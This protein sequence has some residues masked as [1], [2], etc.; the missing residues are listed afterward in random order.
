MGSVTQQEFD[1]I[2]ASF[3]ERAER[4][5]KSA[6]KLLGDMYY[7]GPSGTEANVSAAFP[8]WKKAVENGDY[9]L[10][11]KVAYAYYTGDG[12]EKNEKKALKYYLMATDYTVDAEAEYIVGFFYENGIGCH[13][14]KRKA[15]PYY[16]L[17][18]LKGHAK[19]QW[20]LGMLLFTAKKR[21]GLHW[22]CC[23]HLSGVQDATDALNHFISNGSSAEA[24]QDEIAQIKRYGVN[25]NTSSHEYN[26]GLGIFMSVLKWGCVG[27][28]VAL[29][30]LIIVCGFILQMESAPNLLMV[31]IIGL[32]GYL[33]YWWET[34]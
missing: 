5:D 33:G 7:Q 10:A 9:S 24:I 29:L 16:E 11:T 3:R 20:Q 12:G 30:F 8:W 17:A 22:I 28:F 2:A 19:A 13:A 31:L 1:R 15:I 27:L 32:F 25:C 4:G 18:A 14:N 34:N 26:R 6:M 23:A 21:D